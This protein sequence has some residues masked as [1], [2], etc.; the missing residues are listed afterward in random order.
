M[1]TYSELHNKNGC[2]YQCVVMETFVCMNGYEGK[3]SDLGELFKFTIG[4]PP[5]QDTVRA[6]SVNTVC[7]HYIT[8]FSYVL[9]SNYP[10]Y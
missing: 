9:L 6:F 8:L 2:R 5:V 10:K 4:A 1:A 3:V 7:C